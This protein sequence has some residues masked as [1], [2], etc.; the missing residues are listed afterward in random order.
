MKIGVIVQKKFYGVTV[1]HLPLFMA[2]REKYSPPDNKCEIV[3]LAQEGR[4]NVLKYANRET[5]VKSDEQFN[6]FIDFKSAD[7]IVYF[8]KGFFNSL[9]IFNEEH[10]DIIFCLRPQPVWLNAAIRVSNAK[11]SVGFITK[12]YPLS[13]LC[14]DEGVKYNNAI[15]KALMFLSLVSE[16]KN[17]SKYFENHPKKQLKGKNIF[18]LCGGGSGSYKRYKIENFLAACDKISERIPETNYYF[19]LG[20][21][22]LIYKE[23]IADFLKTRGGEILENKSLYE[24]MSYFKSADG[25]IA[26]DCGPCHI[27]NLLAKPEVLLLYQKNEEVI[28]EWVYLRGNL[29]ILCGAGDINKISPQ[30]VCDNVLQL[31]NK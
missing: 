25:F 22:E 29:K 28:N 5:A 2:L 30:S 8:K 21:D 6:C 9:K 1:A 31:L 24:L 27:A 10:F 13:F 4:D 14:Y 20:N 17:L 7:R 18:I 12:K 3:V 26:N 11:K 16:E 23:K 19:V 15:Y